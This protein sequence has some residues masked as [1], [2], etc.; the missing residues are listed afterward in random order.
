VNPTLASA[1]PKGN[2]G[3]IDV[4]TKVADPTIPPRRRPLAEILAD[5]T[6]SN[7]AKLLARHLDGLCLAHAKWAAWPKVSTIAHALG[8]DGDPRAFRK[9]VERAFRELIQSG[10]VAR[11]RLGHLVAWYDAE[12][13]RTGFAWPKGLRRNLFRSAAICVLGW[14]LA[15]AELA[16]PK[17][18]ACDIGV[19]S[20]QASPPLFAPPNVACHTPEMSHATA[21][22]MS[23]PKNVRNPN[24]RNEPVNVR[25]NDNVAS[26]GE[27]QERR[28]PEPAAASQ[29]EPSQALG[30][31]I[32]PSATVDL[33]PAA[34]TLTTDQV[35][36]QLGHLRNSRSP[37]RRLAYRILESAGM[38]PAE[39]TG[40]YPPAQSEPARPTVPPSAAIEPPTTVDLPPA[41]PIPPATVTEPTPAPVVPPSPEE[42]LAELT[43]LP[44]RFPFLAAL[45]LWAL[46]DQGVPLPSPWDRVK[47]PPRPSPEVPADPPR[48]AA[49]PPSTPGQDPP[50]AERRYFVPPSQ[51]LPAP[52][53]IEDLFRRLKGQPEGASER[54]RELA[55]RLSEKW[56]DRGSLHGFI[57]TLRRVASGEIP[58]KA[59]LKAYGKASKCGPDATPG[60]IFHY[61][62]KEAIGG[63]P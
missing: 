2:L 12:G 15:E 8:W 45:Y 5:P 22:E 20:S 34:P 37:L 56:N 4:R 24:I 1:P 7:G 30:A 9:R 57:P 53:T 18:P 31:T 33:P 54:A 48:A 19:A 59:A 62:L 10:D 38:L 52:S 44:V 28:P 49:S 6:L 46:I 25:E 17:P 47:L 51:Q 13:E 21:T 26:S 43:K 42:C 16:L 36:D 32:E 61:W 11:P 60:A 23:H 58:I 39:F 14:K 35:A 55:S 29:A 63:V 41:A 27:G 3:P 50:P 40:L